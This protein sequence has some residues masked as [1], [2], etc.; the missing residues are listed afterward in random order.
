MNGVSKIPCDIF[1]NISSLFLIGRFE[2]AVST[3]DHDQRFA[4]TSN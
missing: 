1:E 2:L 3:I 4:S